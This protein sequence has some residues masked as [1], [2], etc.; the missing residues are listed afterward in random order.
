VFKEMASINFVHALILVGQ[1]HAVC[2][3]IRAYTWI[4]VDVDPI[5]A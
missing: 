5:L 1:R 2:D 3:Y 4:E